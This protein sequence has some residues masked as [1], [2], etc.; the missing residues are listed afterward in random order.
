VG[1]EAEPAPSDRLPSP[2]AGEISAAP[3]LGMDAPP[4]SKMAA[5][6][7]RPQKML[8]CMKQTSF[9]ERIGDGGGKAVPPHTQHGPSSVST[10]MI[11][12]DVAP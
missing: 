7:T 4:Q 9:N 11:G 10:P 3:A 5:A 1:D 6:M 2:A 12:S 8:A